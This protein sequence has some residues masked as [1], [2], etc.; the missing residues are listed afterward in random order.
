MIKRRFV[1]RHGKKERKSVRKSEREREQKAYF[2]KAK[3]QNDDELI[4]N[5]DIEFIERNE[6]ITLSII[7]NR[8]SNNNDSKERNGSKNSSTF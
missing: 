1:Y 5:V 8:N 2:K 6:G 4:L 7:S 3:Q